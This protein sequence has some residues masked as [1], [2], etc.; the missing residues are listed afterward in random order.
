MGGDADADEGEAFLGEDGWERLRADD[1]SDEY[2]A[3]DGST[4]NLQ[5]HG[6]RR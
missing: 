4:T 3:Q 6:C 2:A 5:N 1:G